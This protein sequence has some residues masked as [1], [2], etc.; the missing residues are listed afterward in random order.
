[1]TGSD[2]RDILIKSFS[3]SELNDLLFDLGV[4]Y[5]N[6]S[7]DTLPSRARETVLYFQRHSRFDELVAAVQK[8]RPQAFG[9]TASSSGGPTA[10][11]TSPATPPQTNAPPSN[12]PAP[13]STA[14]AGQPRRL[15]APQLITLR[16]RLLAGQAFKSAATRDAIVSVL[17][18]QITAGYSPGPNQ[19]VDVYNLLQACNLHD[20]GIQQLVEAV[21]AFETDPSAMQAVDDYLASLA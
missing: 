20:G 2:L 18:P 9:A 8:A 6:I 11:V 12:P 7:G 4:N 10:P 5:E 15:S 13:A 1:M 21:R 19:L 16:S 14:A 3:L 17:D